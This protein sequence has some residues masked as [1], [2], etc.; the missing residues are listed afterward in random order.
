MKEEKLTLKLKIM[1]TNCKSKKVPTC[2]TS[3]LGVLSIKE[4]DALMEQ[5]VRYSSIREVARRRK[6]QNDR[7]K[8]NPQVENYDNKL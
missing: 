1:T 5:G 6:I 3:D 4:Y 8:T 2:P 7:I